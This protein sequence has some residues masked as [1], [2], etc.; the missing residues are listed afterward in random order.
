MAIYEAAMER[1]GLTRYVQ[2]EATGVRD[3]F[4]K[5]KAQLREGEVMRGVVEIDYEEMLELA[6]HVDAQ[7]EEAGLDP[8]YVAAIRSWLAKQPRS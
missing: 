1:S 4:A 8:D 7:G 6:R 5:A 2:L 3:A